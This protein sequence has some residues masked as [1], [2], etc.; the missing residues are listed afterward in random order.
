M[1]VVI[2][3]RGE[4]ILVLLY[5]NHKL[6]SLQITEPGGILGNIYI[7]RVQKVLPGLKAAFVDIEKGQTCFLQK[8]DLH[9]IKGNDEIPVQITAE[10]VKAKPPV[11]SRELTLTGRYCVVSQNKPGLSFSGK[12]PTIIKKRLKKD[13]T[14]LS[15]IY[16]DYHVII[17]T[18]AGE[19]EDTG[20]LQA[21]IRQLADEL[22][23]LRKNASHRTCYSL[24]YQETQ[25]Y[26]KAVRDIRDSEYD[27]IVTDLPD[28]Y[29]ALN[30]FYGGKIRYYQDDMLSLSKLYSVETHL[31]NSLHARVWL[32]MGGFLVIEPTEALTVID[33]NSGKSNSKK[34]TSFLA[35]NKQAAEEVARQLRIRNIS[36]I[37]IVDFINMESEEE[38]LEL[39][40]YMR[41]LIKKDAVKTT[42]VD[43]TPLGLMEITRKKIG[44]VLSEALKGKEG[45]PLP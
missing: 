27:E 16:A 3:K 23:R 11:V 19:S 36:G 10:A 38:K 30:T 9:D 8:G 33:V 1:K 12:L 37:I 31:Q 40:V 25:G 6:Q 2:V 35:L 42:V 43:I 20:P 24:L 22:T 39:L 21:E 7:G 45:L 41:E 5:Q 4:Q 44:K 15:D 17:R 13:L 28:V 32:D 14:G 34:M 29:E 26:A 18:N